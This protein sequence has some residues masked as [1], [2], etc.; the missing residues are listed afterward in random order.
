MDREGGRWGN[1]LM[2]GFM[3]DMNDEVSKMVWKR[4]ALCFLL[5]IVFLVFLG[6]KLRGV[7][8]SLPYSCPTI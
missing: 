1:D 6:Q 8:S 3:N 2:N 4:E 5:Q 7:M